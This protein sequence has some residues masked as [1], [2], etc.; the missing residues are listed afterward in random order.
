MRHKKFKV[1]KLQF[2]FPSG[3]LSD[4]IEVNVVEKLIYFIIMIIIL[5]LSWKY[6]LA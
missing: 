4:Y 6:V 5:V 3:W 1:K 2:D